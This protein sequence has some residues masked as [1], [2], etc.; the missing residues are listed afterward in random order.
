M[1]NTS[2]LVRE[3]ISVN[4]G[5]PRTVEW[6]GKRVTTGIFKNPVQGRVRLHRLNLDGDGQADLTVHGGPDMAVY[7]YPAEHYD[8]WRQEL[9]DTE[10]PWGMFGENFTARGLLEEFINIG[11]RFRIGAAELQVTQPRMPCYK[12]G[13]KFGRDD[14]VK[15]FLASRRTGFYFRV[16]KEGY[17]KAGDP[18]EPI[19]RDENDVTVADITRL[20]VRE[21]V[22]PE[23]L[24]RAADLQ[25]LP[26]SWRGYFRQQ[27]EK[28]SGTARG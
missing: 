27:H 18:I 12:L 22:S 20:Y 24:Q 5:L 19:A 15:R 16:L 1:I 23:L 21:K 7:L 14:M 26:E 13:L 9:P 2:T 8:Y 3:L 17:V 25:A 10:L 4:V 6:R 11:D 28:R